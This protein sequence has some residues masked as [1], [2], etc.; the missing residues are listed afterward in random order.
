VRMAKRMGRD[1]GLANQEPI[2]VAF[3]ELDERVVAE[4]L[5]AP[6]STATYQEDK[7]AFRLL[8]A[9][10]HHIRIERLQGFRLQKVDHPFGP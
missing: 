4:R 9:L 7:G 2:T 1:P 10:V 8:W 5:T 6:L 3:K